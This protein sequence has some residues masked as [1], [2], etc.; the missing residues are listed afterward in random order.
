[1]ALN[2]LGLRGIACEFYPGGHASGCSP[3]RAW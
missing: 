1:M 3:Q 2:Y